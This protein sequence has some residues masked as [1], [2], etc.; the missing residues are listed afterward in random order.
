MRYGGAVGL[1]WRKTRQEAKTTRLKNAINR[2]RRRLIPPRL[3]ENL[4]RRRGGAAGSACQRVG[5]GS[6][7]SSRRRR[8]PRTGQSAGYVERERQD[9]QG[10]VG[11]AANSP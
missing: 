6:A 7:G 8:H 5:R 9:A 3:L 4:R 2:S 1:S 10:P 11:A